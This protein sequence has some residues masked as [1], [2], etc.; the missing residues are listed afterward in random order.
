[1]RAVEQTRERRKE[2]EQLKAAGTAMLRA[3]A[4]RD[5]ENLLDYSLNDNLM[6]GDGGPHLR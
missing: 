3:M 4:T 5:L 1:M 6:P 2:R